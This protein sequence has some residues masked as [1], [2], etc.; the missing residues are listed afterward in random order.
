MLR[1]LTHQ[2]ASHTVPYPPPTGHQTQPAKP[3]QRI[4]IA[5]LT[6]T[7]AIC[8]W[9]AYDYR[10]QLGAKDAQ[11]AALAAERDNE[12]TNARKALADQDTLRDNIERLTRERERLLAQQREPQPPG[13]PPSGGPPGPGGPMPGGPGFGGIAAMLQTPEGKKMFRNQSA[14]VV[15]NQYADFI[16]KRKL[17]PQD[18]EVLINLLA[19]RHSALAGARAASGGDTAQF[20]SQS[21]AIEGE[22]SDKLRATL[23]DQGLDELNDYDKSIPERSALSQIEDQF[24]SAGTPLDATQKES[25]IQLMQAEREK[26]P[27]NPLDPMKSEPGNVLN[28]L[29]DDSTLPTWEK[30]QLDYNQRVLQAAASTLTPDQVNTLK[31]SLAQKLEREKA[32]LQIFKTTGAPPSPPP[33]SN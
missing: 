20:A 23:G 3:M 12:R 32:G 10:G 13:F 15:R 17:S 11:I 19:D 7:M 25:L 29:K 2:R 18:S 27:A 28:L 8:A 33:P 1:H 26:S 31:E 6:V 16:R 14:S 30:Q 21:A 9:L 4:L 24:S 5:I 22:F